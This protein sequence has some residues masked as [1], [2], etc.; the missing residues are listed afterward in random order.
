MFGG[1]L[2]VTP[3]EEKVS[4]T[5]VIQGN[6]ELLLRPSSPDSQQTRIQEDETLDWSYGLISLKENSSTWQKRQ[7]TCD[8]QSGSCPQK[9][10]GE[11]LPSRSGISAEAINT[12]I[13]TKNHPDSPYS[14]PHSPHSRTDSPYSHLDFQRSRPDSPCSHHSPHSVPRFPIPAFTDSQK[15]KE[16]KMVENSSFQKF[17]GKSLFIQCTISW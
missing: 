2:N 17:N 6:L 16:K 8:L 15:K 10:D 13:L 12:K 9:L 3:S 14:H 4:T 1:I 11:M 5:G 7:K